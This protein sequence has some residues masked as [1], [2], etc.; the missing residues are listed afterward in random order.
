MDDSDHI[1]IDKDEYEKDQ[2][3]HKDEQAHIRA[4]FTPLRHDSQFYDRP[5]HEVLRDIELIIRT[6]DRIPARKHN[7][8]KEQSFM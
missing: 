4:L 8:A 7:Y 5:I 6:M 2:K 1:Y 3:N